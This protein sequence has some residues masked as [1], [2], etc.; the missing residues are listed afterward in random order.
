M[1]KKGTQTKKLVKEDTTFPPLVKETPEKTKK[2][3]DFVKIRVE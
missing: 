2:L 1:S 3:L